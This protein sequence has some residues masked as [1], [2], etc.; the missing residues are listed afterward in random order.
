MGMGR[1]GLL[2]SVGVLFPLGTAAGLAAGEPPEQGRDRLTLLVPAYSY[3]SGRGHSDWRKLIEAAKETP[4]VAIANPASG[5][6]MQADPLY[7]ETLKRAADGGVFLVGYVTTSYGKRSVGE[8]RAEL[9][10]WVTT[11]PG[12]RGFFLDEQPSG[13]EHVEYYRELVEAAHE[14]LPEARVI[15]NPG[16]SC[17][18]G[19]L[20]R[21]G[22]DVVCLYEGPEDLSAYRPPE[23]VERVGRGRVAVL[24]HTQK[25]QGGGAKAVH[26]AGLAGYGY[27]FA[28]DLIMPNPWDGLPRDWRQVVAAARRFNLRPAGR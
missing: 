26:Q 16:T 4:V 27:A 14:L 13:A 7:V 1:V 9:R 22:V 8:V 15:S 23:W 25:A 11:Y 17:D 28:T 19:Y 5:P 18:E 10:R 24:C 3:P 21:A 12:I 20:T 6:G 2:L